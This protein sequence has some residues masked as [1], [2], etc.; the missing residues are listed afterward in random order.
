MATIVDDTT[1]KIR[2]P[3][4]AN[5]HL[6]HWI[7]FLLVVVAV[8]VPLLFL[9]LG[10][11]STASLP[12]DF[13]F[14]KMDLSNYEDVW[15][16]PT[17][18]SLFGNTVVY[19]G[20]AT[21]IGLVVAV[22]LAWLVE[23][24]NIPG[25]MWI[26]AGVPM[27][28][29]MPGML[30]AMAWVL[31]LSPKIGFINIFAMWAFHLDSMPFNVYT[32]AGMTIIEGIR[33]VPTAF[34]MLVPLLRSMDP[35]LEEAAAMS[36]AAP[37]AML[38]KV[39][40][41]LMLPGLLAV[42]IY[43]AMT[44]LEVFEVPGILGMPGNIFVFSTKIY[45]IL[46]SPTGIPEYGKG[47]ALA[48]LYVV[49]A[50]VA[51]V[52][53]S[54]VIS[55]SERYSIVTGKGYRPREANLGRWKW[56]AVVLVVLFLSLSIV[57]P[58]LVLM[59]V[60]FLPFMQVPSEKAFAAMSFAN[61]A[62]I[63]KDRLVLQ[64]LWNTATMVA[65]TSTM[66]VIFSFVIAV[67]VVRTKFWGRNILNQ[68]SFMPHAIPGIVMGLAF[69]WVF[70]KLDSWGIPIHGGTI[71]ISIAF[72]V[73][74]MAYGSR[75]MNAAILQIHKD[76]EE[77]AQTS[78]A[79]YWRTMWRVFFPL[80]LPTFVGVWIWSMLHSVRQAGTP[81]MLYEGADNQVLSVFI[82]NL[83][84][85]GDIPLVGAIGTLMILV[86]L[87]ITLLLRSIGFGR[88]TAVQKSK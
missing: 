76:L 21:A 72:T 56:P 47:N 67:V 65:L 82:W 81:L 6:W 1:W 73:G 43:Q 16:D 64:T 58:F 68:L 11:F 26:Y 86:L 5:F 61:Y 37:A 17:L 18:W 22:A 33:L 75:A 31:L 83:W 29:A 57:L 38:R 28:L 70:L 46:H 44:A 63:F 8:S 78:G 39:T 15:Y 49:I 36:G 54:R 19:V 55:R 12:T 30:Q 32:L 59:F 20:G 10:S 9:V 13:S 41:R 51:T 2:Q 35:T 50:I 84:D 48:I 85:R 74:F 23:R 53:Y 45:T 42:L 69:L 79:P 77:A 52:L 62:Q 3:R 40:V 80:M 27:T 14:S 87:V 60:S 66:T 88:G 4:L 7:V 34:L 71:A 25:K 24:T